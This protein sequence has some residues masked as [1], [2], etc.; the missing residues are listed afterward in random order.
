MR[1]TSPVT[2]LV[3]KRPGRLPADLA[4]RG[5]LIAA[6][7]FRPQWL[8]DFAIRHLQVNWDRGHYL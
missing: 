1:R 4:R 2:T 5:N 6:G 8:R 7:C 3:F